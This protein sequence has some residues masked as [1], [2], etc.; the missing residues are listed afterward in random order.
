MY[1]SIGSPYQSAETTLNS[2]V[3]VTPLITTGMLGL[4]RIA[5]TSLRRLTYTTLSFQLEPEHYENC[6][7]IVV[8]FAEGAYWTHSNLLV[9]INS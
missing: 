3:F 2:S 9:S 8:E 4:S 1:V 7:G 5:S 6:D